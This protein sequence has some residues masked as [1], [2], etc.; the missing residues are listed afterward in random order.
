MNVESWIVRLAAIKKY[1][2][3]CKSIMLRCALFVYS[4]FHIIFFK[5]YFDMLATDITVQQ[6]LFWEYLFRIFRIVSLQCRLDR[7]FF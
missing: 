3:F 5:E 4:C 7:K 2:F 6:F 1:L